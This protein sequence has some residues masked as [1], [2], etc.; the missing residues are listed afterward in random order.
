MICI[1]IYHSYYILPTLK[2]KLHEVGIIV[3][4]VIIFSLLR[5][6]VDA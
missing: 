1:A 2:Y 5:N 4:L 3:Y 6:T